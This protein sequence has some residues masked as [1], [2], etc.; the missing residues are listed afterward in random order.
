MK[1][2]SILFNHRVGR[3]EFYIDDGRSGKDLKRPGIQQI[4]LD[5]YEGKI[6]TVL[7]LKLDRLSRRQK[8]VL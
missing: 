8:D 2:E 3:F 6:D 4:L 5:I 1:A 7:V